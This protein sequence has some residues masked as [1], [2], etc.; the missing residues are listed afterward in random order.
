MSQM[1]SKP[2]L[3]IA[4]LTFNRSDYLNEL[5]QSI[6]ETKPEI[7]SEIEILVLDNGSSDNTHEIIN[8]HKTLF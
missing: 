7:M 6:D 2:I 4:I 8:F 3:T 5:L 1:R